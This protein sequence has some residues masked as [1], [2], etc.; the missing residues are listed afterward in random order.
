MTITQTAS[1]MA[2][3]AL[4]PQ[5]DRVRLVREIM[6]ARY[7]LGTCGHVTLISTA[8]TTVK[9]PY[10]TGVTYSH[11]GD[12]WTDGKPFTAGPEWHR[13]ESQ[14]NDVVAQLLTLGYTV[15]KTYR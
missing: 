12:A 9:A 4:C 15:T 14:T 5:C 3:R 11:G 10:S 6:G 8:E 13:T 2:L 1:P 7:V